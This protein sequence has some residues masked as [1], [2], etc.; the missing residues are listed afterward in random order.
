ME[1]QEIQDKINALESQQLALQ[2]VMASSDAHAAKC[3]KLGLSFQTEYPDE[4]TE[5]SA[6]RVEYNDNEAILAE[7]YKARDTAE[8]QAI[9][10][11]NIE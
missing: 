9:E 7:L 2:T 4:F 5:Y 6:A 11:I 3:T 10:P 1:N 8:E